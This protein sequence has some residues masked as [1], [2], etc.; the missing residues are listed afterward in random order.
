[1]NKFKEQK[2]Q[3]QQ[4]YEAGLVGGERILKGR[5]HTIFIWK[6][7]GVKQR[8]TTVYMFLMAGLYMLWYGRVGTPVNAGLNKEHYDNLVRKNAIIHNE[9]VGA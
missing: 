1:M 8:L 6:S 3:W 4:K 5:E 7:K 9:K 2:K